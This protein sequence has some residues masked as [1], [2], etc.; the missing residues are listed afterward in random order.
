MQDLHYFLNGHYVPNLFHCRNGFVLLCCSVFAIVLPFFY[1]SGHVGGNF[2]TEVH[3]LACGGVDKSEGFCVQRLSRANLETVLNEL[4]IFCGSNSAQRFVAAVALIAEQRMPDVAHM[5]AN[6]VRATRF[7]LAF[8]ESN[9]AEVFDN[10][11][12]R[13]GVFALVAVGENRHL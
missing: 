12:V 3:L 6:L 8:D 4:H 10:A 11:I 13:H 5:H 1:Q 7:Q 2:A 9:V